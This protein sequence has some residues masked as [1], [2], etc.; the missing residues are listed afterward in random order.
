MDGTSHLK[1]VIYHD[2]GSYMISN[3]TFPSYFLQDRDSVTTA[4]A[5]LDIAIFIQIAKTMNIS[6]RYVGEE[7]KSFATG[8]YNQVMAKAF[9]LAG[10]ECHIVPRKEYGGEVI[11]ASKVREALQN[12]D[13]NLVKQ[14]VP[15]TTYRY[16]ISVD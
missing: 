1:N 12:N 13:M 4:H 2:S 6:A 3:A 8:I 11:S 15:E 9:P 5:K 10:I 16:F 7:P 14:L